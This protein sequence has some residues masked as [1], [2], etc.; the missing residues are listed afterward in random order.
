M[1][2]N[3]ALVAKSRDLLERLEKSLGAEATDATIAELL[4]ASVHTVRAVRY[5]RRSFSMEHAAMAALALGLDVA[6][7]TLVFFMLKLKGSKNTTLISA[8][9][10]DL[11]AKAEE[12]Q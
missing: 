4:R 3:E 6:K 1:R 10:S 8:L 2:K 7:E 9:R 5:G 12:R 11:R